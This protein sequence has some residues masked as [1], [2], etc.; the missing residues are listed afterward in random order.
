ML[1]NPPGRGLGPLT[2]NQGT[3]QPTGY[4]SLDGLL[5]F[6]NPGGTAARWS[7]GGPQPLRLGRR[8]RVLAR[9][10]V[11]ASSPASVSLAP[12]APAVCQRF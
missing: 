11:D 5:W 7:V 8:T 6:S 10:W 9:N 2:L 1:C 3:A 4:T 12:T